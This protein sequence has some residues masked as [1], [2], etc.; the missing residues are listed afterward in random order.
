MVIEFNTNLSPQMDPSQSSVKRSDPAA[1]ADSASFSSTDSLNGQ[2][3]SMST[4]RPDKV[5][6]AKDL[7]ADGNYPSDKDLSR[8]A[9]LLADH[10]QTDSTSAAE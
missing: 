1:A 9:G 7:V 5:A 4:V 3:S 2:L 6:A 8:I 10:I